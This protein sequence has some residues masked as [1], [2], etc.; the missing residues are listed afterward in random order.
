LQKRTA[1]ITATIAAIAVIAIVI[2][3]L[4]LRARPQRHRVFRREA[5]IT[6]KGIPPVEQ[7][8]DA[9]SQLPPSEL[10]KL[11]DRIAAQHPDLYAKWSLGYL[12]ARALIEDNEPKL[13]AKKLAPFLANGNPFRDLALDHQSEIEEGEA[14]SR[15]RQALIFG[16]PKS[17]YR[18]QAIDEETESLDAHRLSDF[19]AKLYPSADTARRRDL[20][21]HIAE[22]THS[23]EKALAVLRGGTTDDAAE[24]A[25]RVLDAQHK[26]SELVGEVMFN[27][28]HFDRAIALLSS[29][30]S[31]K[32]AI[33][34]AIG[35]SYFGAEKYTEAEQ[36]YIRAAHA[37]KVPAEKAQYLWHAAR[38]VQLRGD[39]AGAEKLMTASIAIPGR[40]PAQTAALTQ[41]I[42]LR[43][44][45]KRIR[46][47]S[48]DLQQL[49][50]I[51]PNDHDVVAA[52]MAF[53]SAGIPVPI[54]P[55]L[56]T[57]YD[58]AELA[59][60]RGR[61]LERSNPHG[62]FTEYVE[63]LK[64]DTPFAQFARARIAQSPLRVQEIA[65][66]DAKIA[67]A[68]NPIEAKTIAT[69]RFLIA[70]SGQLAAIYRQIPQYREVLDAKPSPFPRFPIPSPPGEGRATLLMAMG[71]FDEAS[72]DIPQHWSLLTQSLA[73]NRGNASR[74]SIYDIERFMKSVPA[75]YVDDLLPHVVRE[76]LYP[77]YFDQAIEADS[78]K[79]AADP[80]L[81]LAIMREE[82]RFNPRAK[83]EAAARGLL[84]FIITTARDI[85]REAGIV[86]V[87]PDDLY[88]PHIIIQL[89]AKYI[90]SLLAQ[91]KN[92]HYA[93]SAAYNAGAK[94]VLLWQHMAPAPG[95]DALVTAINFDETKDYVRKVMS[96][97]AQYREIYR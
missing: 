43:L 74:M 80:T 92:D 14:A 83:S 68:K 29:I 89:G 11:L 93:A 95:D 53:L 13:A 25:A 97:Y 37:T 71:L 42:R 6:I 67:A 76:L 49:R 82:S 85:G 8:T 20:D 90:G 61:M 28:R 16:C 62:A 47:A 66:R 38:A 36:E 21:A 9:F 94:Q 15:A 19:A 35:R 24:R 64:E 23:A 1:L 57:K 70:P 33:I 41:R 59:Y 45:Q 30:P 40:S 88:D 78:K 84:Q 96:S 60:W 17:L 46:E 2:G 5:P 58:R 51:A 86:D 27:H 79:F 26:N 63:A 87:T 39:D 81:V 12:H 10:V 52:S 65:A 32:P 77:R 50:T 75:D 48:A 72:D 55:K 44:K 3:I 7:W 73:L 54:E 69:E 22:R 91:F 31:P 4:L 34:F 56:L 18:D